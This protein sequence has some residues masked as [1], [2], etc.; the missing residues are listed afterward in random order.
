MKKTHLRQVS[1]HVLAVAM[2]A[3]LLTGM[4]WIVRGRPPG[5][6][7]NGLDAV[8]PT[9]PVRVFTVGS[10]RPN[11]N[12]SL[13]GVVE[14]R[15][16]TDLAMRV[17][18]KIEHRHI[19]VGAQV[20]LNDHLF[21]LDTTDYKLQLESA[22][23]ELAVAIAAM[24]RADADEQ[25]QKSLL[26]SGSI[27]DDE[28]DNSLS[29]RDIARGRR[30]V[31]ERSLE[32]ARNRLS[33]TT[34]RTPAAG[35]ILAVFAESG[36]MVTEGQPVA[37]LAH[38]GERELVVNIPER[39]L[40]KVS[41]TEASISYWS[42]PGVSSKTRLRELSPNADPMTRTF[43]ARFTIVDPPAALQLGMTAT[44]HLE[45]EDGSK[46]AILLPATT[47]VGNKQSPQ[48]WK[49]TDHDGHIQAVP[50][51]VIKFT[52]NEILVRGE[53]KDGDQIVSAGA[54]KLDEHVAV[55][56]WEELR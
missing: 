26:A 42:M 4:A 30:V 49:V 5:E 25:R 1:V 51:E 47:L 21:Q 33:Y 18:G 12:Y 9:V 52:S 10:K 56:K 24:K 46:D 20:Q 54:H 29:Q 7:G 35:R 17:G 45:D 53:L 28:Y 41:H 48:V 38:D 8:Q 14:A 31:A 34:L 6:A 16:V 22:E 11:L 23:A 27:S 37:R 50:V 13:T 39:W 44:L 3:I 43:V 36:Q 15:Y 19:N 2:V 40:A 55:R 32:L